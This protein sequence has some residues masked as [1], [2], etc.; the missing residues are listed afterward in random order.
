M[1]AP[2]NPPLGY[3]RHDLKTPGSFFKVYYGR[4]KNYWEADDHCRNEDGAYLATLEDPDDVMA[5]K[6]GQEIICFCLLQITGGKHSLIVSALS[7]HAGEILTGITRTSSNCRQFSCFKK[8]DGS[9][10]IPVRT[11]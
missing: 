2:C 10:S 8:R 9:Q 4:A 7:G 11:L 3:T 5:V 1:G 6:A